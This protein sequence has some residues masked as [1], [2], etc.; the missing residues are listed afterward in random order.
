[1]KRAIFF[2]I[3]LLVTLPVMVLLFMRYQVMVHE[4][5]PTWEAVR[6]RLVPDGEIAV[7]MPQGVKILSVKCDDPRSQISIRGQEVVTKV[8]YSWYTL[9]IEAE[10]K[11]SPYLFTFNPQKLN[12]WNRIRFEPTD[13]SNPYSDFTKSENGVRG[14]HS[15]VIRKETRNKTS[16]LVP[17]WQRKF[18]SVTMTL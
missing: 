10:I 6:N 2:V 5:Y 15:D 7:T 14:S 4:G 17:E 1:M 8:G 12:H 11:G 13:A 9:S 18:E 3:A 16:F